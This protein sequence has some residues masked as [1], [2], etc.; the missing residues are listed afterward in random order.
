MKKSLVASIVGI[1]SSNLAALR[2]ASSCGVDPLAL[3]RLRDRLAVL[4]GAGEEEDVL[5]ALAHVP[6]ED[7]GG[8][9]RVR[10]AEVGL[11]VDV[12]DR[13][14]DVEAGVAHLEPTLAED[15]EPLELKCL[16]RA[17]RPVSAL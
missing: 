8:D 5:A 3:G 12:V 16:R 1:S 13:G 4:V 10:V 6:G 15:K 9:R 7:V 14:G 11:G 17:S 2:S